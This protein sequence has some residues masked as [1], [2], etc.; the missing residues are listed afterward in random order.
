LGHRCRN[1]GTFFWVLPE[2]EYRLRMVPWNYKL[3]LAVVLPLA[4]FFVY[5]TEAG[6]QLSGVVSGF[7]TGVLVELRW[8][9]FSPEGP[10]RQRV[11]RFLIGGVSLVA[12]WLG[13]KAIFPSEPEMVGLV[14]RLIR[15]ALVGAW[16][17]LGAPWF[18][19]RI[20]LA[21][22]EREA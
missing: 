3:A 8:V 10:L 5:A 7:T 15:Y 1:I 16:A 6:A 21:P 17:S 19:V 18:F 20:G 2:A 13:F 14:F 4:L 12:V 22:R 11:S 9:G